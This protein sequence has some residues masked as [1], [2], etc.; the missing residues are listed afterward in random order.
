[1][2]RAG[3]NVQSRRRHKKVLDAAKGYFGG[4]RKLYTVAKS[5]VDKGRQYALRDRR[6]KKRDF[7]SLWIVRINAAVREHGMSYAR[8][9]AGYV[10]GTGQR[11]VVWQIPLGN[12]KM[13]SLDNTW[14]HYQDN[15]AG[16]DDRDKVRIRWY[17]ESDRGV[18][19][20][21]EIKRRRRTRNTKLH[22]DLE[23]PIDLDSGATWNEVLLAVR[24]ELPVRFLAEVGS[25]W[26]P[27]P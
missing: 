19:G 14:G 5:A 9:I 7:R 26:R 2:S 13:R 21:L 8:F 23:R 6:L 25:A 11:V 12:T 17:G 3:V 24:G 15:R 20:A 1:M 10:A 22:H 16:L 27:V 18:P 4:R